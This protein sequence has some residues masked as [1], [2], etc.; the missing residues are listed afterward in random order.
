MRLAFSSFV[1]LG[2]STLSL[3]STIQTFTLS[4]YWSSTLSSD[5]AGLPSYTRKLSMRWMTLGGGNVLGAPIGHHVTTV[6][7]LAT[8]SGVAH[9]R[10]ACMWSPEAIAGDCHSIQT[11]HADMNQS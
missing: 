2:L 6:L 9:R 3:F 10:G 7:I 1:S 11:L 5:S 4:T 8:D